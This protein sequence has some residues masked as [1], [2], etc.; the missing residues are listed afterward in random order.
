MSTPPTPDR[1]RIKLIPILDIPGRFCPDV[2]GLATALERE[3]IPALHA[4]IQEERRDAAQ[5]MRE[6]CAITQ[7]LGCERGIFGHGPGADCDEGAQHIRALPD[8]EPA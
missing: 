2:P 1:L 4:L 5:K 6:R 7:C 3:M 8:E